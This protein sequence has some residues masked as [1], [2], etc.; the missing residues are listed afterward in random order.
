MKAS[1]AHTLVFLPSLISAYTWP[2]PQLDELETQRYDRNGYNA[3]KMTASVQPCSR[4]DFGV[5]GGRS[6]AADW[7]RTV[8]HDMATFDAAAG[9]GGIDGSIRLERDRPENVGDAFANTLNVISVEANRYV[10]LAD[11]VVLAAL[12][13][14]EE[15]GGPKL[16][17]KGGRVDAT[18]PNNVGVPQPQDTL[19]SHISAFARQGFSQEEM[20]SLV[21]CGHT[22][23]GVQHVSF[24][25]IVPPS[26]DPTNTPGQV[27]FDSTGTQ[28][29]NK[30]VTE[31][32][33]GSTKSP[34]VVGTN[35]TTNSDKR[36]YASDGNATVTRLSD[37]NT[38][39]STCATLF[40]K[41]FDSVPKGVQL[42]DVIEPLPVKPYSM[43]LLHG[44]G[45][46]VQLSGQ[47]RFWNT[48]ENPK[49]VVKLLWADHNGQ[50]CPTC[51]T[52]LSHNQNQVSTFTIG[53]IKSSWYSF[54]PASAKSKAPSTAVLLDDTQTISK[55]WFEVDEG[56]G[57]VVIQDQNGVGFALQDSRLMLDNS[58][59]LGYPTHVHIGVAVQKGSNPKRVYFKGDTFSEKNGTAPS[60]NAIPITK[61][62]EIPKPSGSSAISQGNYDI[63]S[64]T[65]STSDWT[66]G[67]FNVAA[68]FDDGTVET[69][70]MTNYQYPSCV[71][72]LAAPPDPSG[73]KP[74]DAHHSGASVGFNF[75]H[76]LISAV[77]IIILSFVFAL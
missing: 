6:N 71:G 25:D 16:D 10:S 30:I 74:T 35:D 64:L 58:T 1:L 43:Q 27:L 4:F 40:A 26:N 77:G 38:F 49:R 41:M 75:V 68:D 69:P 72:T 48:E 36:I 70:Y 2:N 56:D 3:R 76:F 37:L 60:L 63:W 46:T 28:F 55:V 20:I 67:P 29:D 57:K 8:Y 13:A 5:S 52:V 54:M 61:T 65:L 73:S 18:E 66:N 22:F 59:C 42:T 44:N 62:I 53:N 19:E 45:S 14:V 51:S 33:D 7:I 17:F 11:E 15:C 12:I 24:P 9:T 31:Y 39:T 21:A 32:L 34:L 47:V 23:G 50:S